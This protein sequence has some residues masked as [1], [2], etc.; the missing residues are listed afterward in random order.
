MASIEIW[1]RNGLRPLGV[2]ENEKA[3][4]RNLWRSGNMA[5]MQLQRSWRKPAFESGWRLQQRRKPALW[6]NGGFSSWR[7]GGSAGGICNGA[8]G[9]R[10]RLGFESYLQPERRL[11]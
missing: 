1:R 6:L 8:G 11:A 10:R 3:N 2:S 9:E 5:L 4:H 7:F